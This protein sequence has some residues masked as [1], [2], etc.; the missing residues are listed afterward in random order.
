LLV[1]NIKL[2]NHWHVDDNCSIAIST[3]DRWIA[4]C[5]DSFSH[6][7]PY[8]R[9]ADDNKEI[10]V[11][12]N[13]KWQREDFRASLEAKIVGILNRT[14]ADIAAVESWK[15]AVEMHGRFCQAQKRA[16][17]TNAALALAVG[18]GS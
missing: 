10:V 4:G 9:P 1:G 18:G 16:A 13:G 14:L 7:D 12:A 8:P 15:E 11:W 5:N 2:S 3:S 6:G 17:E